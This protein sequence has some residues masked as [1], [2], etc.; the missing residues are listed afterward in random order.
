MNQFL[1]TQYESLPNKDEQFVLQRQF[2]DTEKHPINHRRTYQSR[3]EVPYHPRGNFQNNLLREMAECPD[4]ITTNQIKQ[5]Q[6]FLSQIPGE[7]KK[8]K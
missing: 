6:N 8:C 1:I 7:W 3:Q 2:Q 4:S 5:H